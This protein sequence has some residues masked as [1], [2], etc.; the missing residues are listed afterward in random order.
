PP[1][2]PSF[3]TRR[4]SDLSSDRR[5]CTAV[6]REREYEAQD[7]AVDGAG[8]DGPCPVCPVAQSQRRDSPRHKGPPVEEQGMGRCPSENEPKRDRKST[9]LN[10]S[11]LGI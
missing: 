2:L 10:S 1:D 5:S 9:R 11:H 4:S 7:E 3:P 8:S 6:G